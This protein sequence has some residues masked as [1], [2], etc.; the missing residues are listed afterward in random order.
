MITPIS[1]RHDHGRSQI[2][3]PCK[4]V[5]Y[6]RVSI[7]G[8]NEVAACHKTATSRSSADCVRSLK[9]GQNVGVLGARTLNGNLL[10]RETIS[11]FKAHGPPACGSDLLRFVLNAFLTDNNLLVRGANHSAEH[12]DPIQ[13]RSVTISVLVLNAD[14]IVNS[15]VA[16]ITARQ[17]LRIRKAGT[18][19]ILSGI[20]QTFTLGVN[21]RLI[22]E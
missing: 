9:S 13:T 22:G 20:S 17:D 21:R 12:I 15:N 4:D 3:G 18:I 6:T 16:G 7:K 1:R 11:I 10:I 19:Y 8:V 2:I 14:I 5:V